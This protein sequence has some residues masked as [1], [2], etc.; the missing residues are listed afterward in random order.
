[1]SSSSFIIVSALIYAWD[2]AKQVRVDVIKESEKEKNYSIT[3]NLFFGS[4]TSF[5]EQF[6]PS[7]DPVDVHVDFAKSKVCDHSGIEVIHVLSERYK[8][9]GKTLHL[10][11]LSPDCVTLLK[12]AGD[13]VEVSIKEDP[14][15][16]IA[17]DHLD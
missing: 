14:R 15:Y 5:K 4:I 17:D 2:S 10:H 9:A 12:K 13:L 6:Q 11:H 1:M 7:S 3:G 16:H 8:S